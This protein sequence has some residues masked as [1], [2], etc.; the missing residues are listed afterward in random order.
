MKNDML[1]EV[2]ERV[3]LDIIGQGKGTCDPQRLV[4]KDAQS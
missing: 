2:T 4:S 3:I 1:I